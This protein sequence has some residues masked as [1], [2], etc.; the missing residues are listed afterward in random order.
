MKHSLLIRPVLLAT[1]IFVATSLQVLSAQL[2]PLKRVVAGKPVYTELPAKS[3]TSEI[4]VKLR[5]GEPRP[6]LVG[7]KFD[8]ANEQLVLINGIIDAG[9]RKSSIVRHMS[10]PVEQIDML[11][12]RAAIR[13]ANAL[14]D[15]NLYFRVQLDPEMPDDEKLAAVAAINALDVVEIAYFAPIPFLPSANATPNWELS[16][17]YLDPAPTG[18]D[19]RAGWQHPGG[20]GEGVKVIDIEGNWVESHEDLRGGV[21]GFHIAGSKIADPTWYMHG[22]A[23]LGEIASDSNTFGMTGIAYNVDL[24]TVSIGSMNLA[25]ALGIA[26][27]NS[28]TG[29]II[30][31]ELQ[32]GGPNGG[33]YVP[34]E[35]Y[36]DQFDAILLASSAG[37]I[38]VEAGANGAQNLDDTFWYGSLF[39]PAFRFSGA[40]MVA[41][42]DASHVP[43]WFTSYGQRL[44]VHGFGSNV[45][46]L[47]YGDLYGSDTTT[48]YTAGF[49]GTSSASPIIVG[50]CAVLQGIHKIVHARVLDHNE[51]RALLKDYSTPQAPSSKAIGPMPNLAGSADAVVGVSF[52]ADTTVGWVP[53]PVN[54]TG[55]SGLTVDT[56][57]WDFG[58]G[59]SASFQSPTHTYSVPGLHDV[60]LQI[61]SGIE[62][63]SSSKSNY[64]IALADTIVTIDTT[65]EAGQT[66]EVEI[67]VRNNIPI[68]QLYIPIQIS[69][70]LGATLSSFNT[71]GCRTDYFEQQSWVQFDPG[72]RRYTIKLVS[73]TSGGSPDLAAGFGTVLK[74]AMAIP[75]SAADGEVDT[76]TIADYGTNTLDFF[77]LYLDYTPE[78]VSGTL[79]ICVQHGDMDG[80]PGLAITDL[81]FLADYLF[82]GGIA[83]NPLASGDYN[84]SGEINIVDLTDFADYLFGQGNP[85]CS[86]Q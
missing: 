26:T 37:R 40:I 34:A 54:F 65:G 18:I 46:T 42:G 4:I 7:G 13:N 84:C 79:S 52:S 62:T 75:S 35:Y 55:S 28:D 85:P 9:S 48:Y 63:R 53:Y 15:M 76:I 24:G 45:Y 41:A 8:S 73:S 38:V 57:T 44:D 29:D 50:A 64:I 1:L 39:D 10:L 11:R 67:Y 3:N 69:G 49:S 32:Y 80:T 14:P 51:M 77:G 58:D 83:P 61:T 21:G 20:H 70:S 56:W 12:S 82:A 33:A 72:N 60:S 66:V 47:G 81:T 74:L 19:A 23:V 71:V 59:D 2:H 86:C 36:Q 6:A 5:E 22:T 27:S 25:S 68:Q 17:N 16:E 78:S 43:E 31:I 30:L